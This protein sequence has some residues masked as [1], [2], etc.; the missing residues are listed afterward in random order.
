MVGDDLED[1]PLML[2]D[3]DVDDEELGYRDAGCTE[4]EAGT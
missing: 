1:S 2:A 3:G 4:V